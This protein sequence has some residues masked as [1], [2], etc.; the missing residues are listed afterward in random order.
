[1]LNT[2]YDERLTAFA[3]QTLT[4]AVKLVQGVGGSSGITL[5]LFPANDNLVRAVTITKIDSGVGAVQVVGGVVNIS[6]TAIN[7]SVVCQYSGGTW[8][9]AATSGIGGGGGGTPAGANGTLQFN[10]DG[11]FGGVLNSS[12]DPST[13]D[14]T[15]GGNFE[16][17]SP[18]SIIFDTPN[19][20]VV[21]NDS[22]G[23]KLQ[24]FSTL[25]IT[26]DATASGPGTGP[27]NL[28]S[29]GGVSITDDSTAGIV[30]T[31][32]ADA[33]ALELNCGDQYLLLSTSGAV[34]LFSSVGQ[35]FYDSSTEGITIDE[36]GGS[37]VTI[38]G[39]D[40]TI[41]IDQTVSGVATLSTIF[42]AVGGYQANGVPGISGSGST[43]TGV[44]VVNGIITAATFS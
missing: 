41:D 10:D 7:Q 32:I 16:V 13:G 33:S 30:I 26:I 8:T 20:A 34:E 6:L 27:I 19:Q 23:V 24:E 15:L 2:A 42:N 39:P 25:G 5:T 40:S 17:D 12:V 14:V 11:E 29:A 18:S 1:M 35:T 43:M 44:T 9:V 38:S 21:L 37:G 28:T 4:Q 22:V 3:S 36:A 31:E